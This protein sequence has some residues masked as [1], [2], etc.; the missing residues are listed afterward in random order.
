MKDIKPIIVGIQKSFLTKKEYNL[1][2][3][4]K[5]IGYIIFS[6]NI[7]SLSRLKSLILLLKSINPNCKTIIMIDHEGGRVNRFNNILDQRKLTA[8]YFGDLFKTNIKKF[9]KEINSF[10]NCNSNLFNFVGINLVAA[11]VLDIFYK[12]K[13]NVIGDRAFSSDPKDIKKIGNILITKYKKN[14]IK[15][16]GKHVP[17]HGLSKVDSHF[18]LPIVNHSLKYL[19]ENDISCFAN[20]RSDFLMTAHILFSSIDSKN[21]ASHSNIIINKIIKKN[22]RFKGLIMSDDL[23][24][25]SLRGPILKRAQKSLLAGCDIVLHCNGNYCEMKVLLER[26]PT[27]SSTL[28]KKINKIFN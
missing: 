2:T 26:L 11:P 23:N 5:P 21:L 6:R 8:K 1:F 22:L 4:F 18:Y 12:K 15:S 16:I 28:I 17:G 14:K 13:S 25:K 10:V 20:I 19:T 3:V 24:M 27:I 7:K 9:Y